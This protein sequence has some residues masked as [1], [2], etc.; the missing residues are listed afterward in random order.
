[1]VTGLALGVAVVFAV[2]IA[3]ESAKRAFALSV[4]AVAGRTTHQLVSTG[5]GIDESIYSRLR[6]E[7]GLRSL[8]Y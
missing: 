1:M 2:D 6:V 3:N 8:S 5:Q 7:M 4:D